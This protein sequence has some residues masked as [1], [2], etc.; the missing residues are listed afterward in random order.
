M[1]ERI[2]IRI[3]D[4]L[5]EALDC[6]IAKRGHHFRSK[7]DAYRFAIREWLVWRGYLD[8]GGL[9]P[10]SRSQPDRSADQRGSGF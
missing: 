10:Q 8:D 4:D 1:K 2:T 5:S 9:A 6:F 7:Q 3:D